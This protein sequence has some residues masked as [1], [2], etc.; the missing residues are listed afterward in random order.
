MSMRTP[1]AIF[2][3]NRPTHLDRLLKSLS[4]CS[5]LDQIEIIYFCDGI[6]DVGHTRAV[7]KTRAIAR[8]W[9]KRLGGHLV[10]K[11][12]NHGLAGSILEGTSWLCRDFGRVIVLEDDLILNRGFLDFHLRALDHYAQTKEIYQISG[13]SF[14]LVPPA[15]NKGYLLP[16]ISTWG[17]S[18]WE[19]AWDQ[20]HPSS[21]SLAD[22]NDE[23]IRHRFNLEGSYDYSQMLDDSLQ[24]RNNS[25]GI[26]WNWHV[27][28]SGGAV[29]YPPHSLVHNAGYDS[30]GFHCKASSKTETWQPSDAE[31]KHYKM[32]VEID[33]PDVNAGASSQREHLK[34]LL[35]MM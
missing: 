18:T 12:K 28:K 23:M 6:K 19:R 16:I 5:R 21:I 17:W 2:G 30:S 20:F 9:Q 4:K 3:Y 1:V 22:L 13:F 14:R 31:V 32:P 15:P 11:P 29:L 10:E 27:F 34:A 8:K 35:R 26:R 33:F 7:A 24:G 25:W